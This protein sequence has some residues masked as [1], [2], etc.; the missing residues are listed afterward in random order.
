MHGG[1]ITELLQR[2]HLGDSEAFDQ[3][4]SLVYDYLRRIARGQIARGG[5]SDTLDTTA[6]VHE[7]YL[8]LARDTGIAFNDRNHFYAICA[9]AMR[10]ILVDHA[11]HRRARK[12]SADCPLVPLAFCDVGSEA[13]P[14]L[15]VGG[16]EALT[17]PRELD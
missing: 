9:R 8:Q 12:R 3:V 16:D 13:P 7:A 14:A 6:L 1:P 11:R 17:T 2:H 4:V 5:P 15:P 10:R